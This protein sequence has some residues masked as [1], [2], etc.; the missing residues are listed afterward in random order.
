MIIVLVG[1]V[2]TALVQPL[3]VTFMI[4]L[5]IGDEAFRSYFL[6]DIMA[7]VTLS[8]PTGT[9]FE[10][11][12]KWSTVSFVIAIVCLLICVTGYLK[13]KDQQNRG[14]LGLIA[15]PD[16]SNTLKPYFIVYYSAWLLIYWFE[17]TVIFFGYIGKLAL[18]IYGTDTVLEVNAEHNFIGLCFL[19]LF[20]ILITLAD[21]VV[22]DIFN[23][24][25][26]TPEVPECQRQE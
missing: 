2:V 5:W 20:V 23:L 7:L 24:R 19:V 12:M 14:I 11:L 26:T 1:L 15:S 8:N 18:M 9:V 16:F 13:W 10:L 25:T 4:L 17:I 6:K 3:F 21:F 22:Q